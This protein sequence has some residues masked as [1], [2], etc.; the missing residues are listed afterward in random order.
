MITGKI[1]NGAV[2][3]AKIRTS[4]L[5]TVPSAANA[6]SLGGM[7]ADQIQQRLE[8]ALP[9]RYAAGRRCSASRLRSEKPRTTK[10][11]TSAGGQTAV[12]QTSAS[13]LRLPADP[14]GGNRELGRIAVPHCQRVH[15]RTFVVGGSKGVVFGTVDIETPK[16]FRC[17]AQPTN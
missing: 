7:S 8:V 15:R 9:S 13:W 1:K 17:A 5:G 10:P 14:A 2:T 4:T 16:T 3:G 6:Q 11:S 12:F